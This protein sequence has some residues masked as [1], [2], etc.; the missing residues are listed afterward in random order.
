MKQQTKKIIA[1]TIAGMMV[2][3]TFAAVVAIF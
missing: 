2:I 1:I 3:S